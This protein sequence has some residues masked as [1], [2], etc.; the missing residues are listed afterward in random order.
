M[1]E[2]SLRGALE[3]ENIPAEELDNASLQYG[4]SKGAINEIIIV[5]FVYFNRF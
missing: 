4:K 3:A 2:M 5:P 1:F